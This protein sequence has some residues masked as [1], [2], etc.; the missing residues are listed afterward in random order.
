[1]LLLTAGLIAFL[2]EVRLSVQAVHVRE[3]LLE[4]DRG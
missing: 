3:E 4:R 2:F 1:M